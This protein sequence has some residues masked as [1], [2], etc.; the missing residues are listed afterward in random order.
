MARMPCCPK[1]RICWPAF[2]I[3]LLTPAVGRAQAP[4]LANDFQIHATP[5]FENTAEVVPP[6]P[7]CPLGAVV[8][9]PG[10][11]RNSVTLLRRPLLTTLTAGGA[12]DTTSPTTEI[13]YPLGPNQALATDNQI[14]RLKDGSLL[15]ARDAYF[16]DTLLGG[17]SAETVTG[18]G[19]HKGQRGGILFF[20]STDC[21]AHW[22]LFST[23]DFGTFLAGKY[24]APRPMNAAGKADVP[25]AEQGKHPDGSL[26]W[27]VGGGDRTEVYVCPFTGYV[28]L[29]TRVVSVPFASLPKQN[30]GLLLISRD[31][32]KSWTAVRENLPTW[33]PLVMT[34]T[35][36]GRLFLFQ[37]VGSQP[38]VYFSKA[39]V[40]AVGVPELSGGHP[41]ND[42]VDGVAVPH[43]MA[44][45]ATVDLFYQAFHPSISRISTN[46]TSSK[47]RVAY[48][49]VNPDGRQEAHVLA[50]EVRDPNKPPVVTPVKVVRAEDPKNR[51]VLYFNFVDADPI[52]LPPGVASDTSL[53]Y[54]LEVPRVGPGTK[55]WSVR[56]M[57]FSGDFGTSCPTHLSVANGQPAPWTT[58]QDAGDY[59]S[60][61]FYWT[62]QKLNYLAQW[63]EPTGIRANVVSVPYQPPAAEP[64]RNLT[65]VWEPGSG[66]EVQVFD[67]K[68]ADFRAKYDGLWKD[69]WRLHLLET[70]VDAGVPLYSAV[71][72]KAD[73]GEI[74]VYGWALADFRKKYDELWG[75]GWRLHLLD[76]F[77]LDGK[78]LYNAVWRPGTTGETQVYGWN[79]ADFRK[80]YD[81]LWGQG[82]RLHLLDTAVL[83]GKLLYSAVWRPGTVGETQVYGW[84]LADLRKKYDELWGKGWRLHLIDSAV[85]DG[86]VLYS[87][88]WRPSTAG[89]VQVYGWAYRDFRKKHDDLW[90]EGWRLK[91]LALP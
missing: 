12:L 17:W 65:A 11:P 44:D 2:L 66:E 15:V 38:T 48:H 90:C 91:E 72:R 89:E 79:L 87:A 56:S 49:A 68:L 46:T 30:T 78:L 9:V 59:M 58:R 7:G 18:S 62:D 23:L 8:V 52:V 14:V 22:T 4:V 31:L 80:K 69:G 43:G 1:G 26:K 63:V 82:W 57:V 61:G 75:K 88:V 20:R 51:S 25:P 64:W 47:V 5:F 10:Q 45:P 76:S 35:P 60:G 54:W 73:T 21:G 86:K 55:T 27:W 50:V 81:E 29:T 42:S 70:R 84:N 6:G 16:W 74:Q 77:V 33:S 28:Y 71:W 83:D 36:N 37:S 39:P 41:I 34:S 85:L 3:V 67:R 32:G 40:G 24:G 13:A 19:D 53:A